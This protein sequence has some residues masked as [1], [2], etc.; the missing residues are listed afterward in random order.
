MQIREKAVIGVMVVADV[1]RGRL[2]A[3][4]DVAQTNHLDPDMFTGEGRAYETTK[5]SGDEE[6]VVR[7]ITATQEKQAARLVF[8][9]DLRYLPRVKDSVDGMRS[10][11]ERYHVDI[12]SPP[13]VDRLRVC[14]TAL[15]ALICGQEPCLEACNVFVLDPPALYERMAQADLV[16]DTDLNLLA[17]LPKRP[18]ARRILFV[19][20]VGAVGWK[21]CRVP[22]SLPDGI[23]L[24]IG[25]G[26]LTLLLETQDA[27]AA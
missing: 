16:V 10:L 6:V 23:D 1:W 12:V 9:G 7:E 3:V 22:M 4:Q 8:G 14:D 26:G 11:S 21:K 2:L 13:K 25:H 20:E 17:S 5:K 24:A 15:T 27:L 19:R 18:G